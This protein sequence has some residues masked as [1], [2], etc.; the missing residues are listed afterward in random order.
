MGDMVRTTTGIL[1]LLLSLLWLPSTH[2]EERPAGGASD[3]AAAGVQWFQGRFTDALAE[4]R[5]RKV[6]LM[7]DVYATWCGPCHALDREVFSRGEVARA[8]ADYVAVKVD[9]EGDE[10]TQVVERYHVV[11]FPTVL[12]LDSEGKEI[13]RVFGYLPWQ[14]FREAM[15]RFHE[16]KGTLAELTEQARRNPLDPHLAYELGFRHAVRGDAQAALVHFARLFAARRLLRRRGREAERAASD[17]L[18]LVPDADGPALRTA[19]ATDLAALEQEVER[20]LPGVY[21]VLGKYLYLRGRKDYASAI[22]LLEALQRRYPKSPEAREVPYQ[23][24]IA[25]HRSG[26]SEEALRLLR[27]HLQRVGQRPEEVNAAAWLCYREGLARSWARRLAE[28]TLAQHPEAA[29]LWDTLAELR[30]ATGD[31]EGA[32]E[33]AKRARAADPEEPYYVTQQQRFE[34]KLAA[35]RERRSSQPDQS[36]ERP[37]TR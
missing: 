19:L 13:D 27:A 30:A 25:Y 31:L 9:A 24:A 18:R 37:T 15:R 32:V 22:R 35:G 26:R 29:G 36:D 33:A 1:F 21:L 17:A 16:G 3:G 23:L 7:V 10:G 8:A 5:A 2:A 11:G 4:A 20:L 28:E 34:A 12:F 6:P 14:E